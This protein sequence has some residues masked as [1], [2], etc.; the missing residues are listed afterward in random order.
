MNK[1][2]AILLATLSAIFWGANFNV[3]KILIGYF[4]PLNLAMIRFLCSFI[5]IIPIVLWV[6]NRSTIIQMIRRNLWIYLVLS[7]IGVCLVGGVEACVSSSLRVYFPPCTLA[8]QL[9]RPFRSRL[10]ALTASFL[11]EPC[12]DEPDCVEAEDVHPSMQRNSPATA[13][14]R[15][16]SAQAQ[17]QASVRRFQ[18]QDQDLQE[19]RADSHHD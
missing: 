4:A 12:D 7:I 11:Q 14:P 18:R 10:D 19:G 9:Q 8:R 16:W 6:E 13:W 5:L 1:K 3:G 15:S 2:M 17:Y